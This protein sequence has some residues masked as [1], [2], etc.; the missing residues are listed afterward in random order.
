MFPFSSNASFCCVW[1][2]VKLCTSL[3]LPLPWPHPVM[4]RLTVGL[5]ALTCRGLHVRPHLMSVHPLGSAHWALHPVLLLTQF[6]A[7]FCCTSLPWF[8]NPATVWWL[9]AIRFVTGTKLKNHWTRDHQRVDMSTN[10]GPHRFNDYFQKIESFVLSAAA[11]RGFTSLFNVYQKV[12][13]AQWFCPAQSTSNV[14]VLICWKLSLLCTDKPLCLSTTSS[15]SLLLW[16]AC[17]IGVLSC[18]C[19]FPLR[20]SSTGS[21]SPSIVGRQRRLRFGGSH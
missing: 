11:F 2:V 6:R 18:N 1:V 19:W 16:P 10:W 13:K 20:R 21:S 8:V 9:C 3:H 7:P 5:L 14:L 15:L 4:L 17:Y 12:T